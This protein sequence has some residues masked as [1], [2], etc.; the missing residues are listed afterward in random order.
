MSIEVNYIPGLVLTDHTFEVP[1][2][3]SDPS[4]QKIRVFGRE[5]VAK[6]FEERDAKHDFSQILMQGFR[7]PS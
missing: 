1:L 3:Y 2:D 6:E 7:H 5:V 4:G